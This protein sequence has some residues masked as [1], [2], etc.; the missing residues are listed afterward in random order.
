[1]YPDDTLSSAPSKSISSPRKRK[2]T[3]K[4]L[5]FEIFKRD[6]FTCQYCGVQPPDA[7]L[8]VDHITPVSAGGDNDPLNL[9]T[10]CETCNQGKADK[11]LVQRIVR[12]D[13]D[14]LYLE[15]QQEIAEIQRYRASR[16][17]RD[18]HVEMLIADF[19]ND[20]REFSS[21]NWYPKVRI[22]Q[23]FITKYGYEATGEAV[24]DVAVKVGTGYL[25]EL[26][27]VW[28]KYM[29]AVARNLVDAYE[30]GD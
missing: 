14:L 16:A 5:R 22:L 10:A 15:T 23:Q 20:W 29:H 26:D 21:L 17:E 9:I 25:P 24:R 19:Q 13:A 7:V 18:A 6:S 1:M 4:R 11:P 2:S 30:E 3:G 12:P 27:S 8:V 28:L